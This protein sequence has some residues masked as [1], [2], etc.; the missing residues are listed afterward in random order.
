[1]RKECKLLVMLLSVA[2]LSSCT[3]AKSQ[4][5]YQGEGNMVKAVDGCLYLKFT[6]WR[7]YSYVHSH[8]CKNPEHARILVNDIITSNSQN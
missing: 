6:G 8:T 3:K 7:E 2:V 1:M 4:E 5:E